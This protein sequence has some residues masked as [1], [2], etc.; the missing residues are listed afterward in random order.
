MEIARQT[1][2]WLTFNIFRIKNTYWGMK[3]KK[4]AVNKGWGSPL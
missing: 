2:E 4:V 1:E 3:R